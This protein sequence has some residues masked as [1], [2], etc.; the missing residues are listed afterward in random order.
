MEAKP[1]VTKMPRLTNFQAEC[2]VKN[3]EDATLAFSVASALITSLVSYKV[4]HIKNA[5]SANLVSQ[6][7]DFVF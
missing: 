5:D 2:S 6:N 7:V 3:D 1:A 4:K